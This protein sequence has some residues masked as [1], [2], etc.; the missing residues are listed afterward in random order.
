MRNLLIIAAI[1]GIAFTGCKKDKNV[2]VTNITI[3][4]AT[5]TLTVGEK[6]TL[7]ATVEPADASNKAVTWNSENPE[8]AT[9]NSTTGE[10]TAIAEG[11][12]VITATANDGSNISDHCFV[13]VTGVTL[14]SIAVTTQPTKKIY[15]LSDEFDPAGMVVTATYS[16]NSKESV[17]FGELEFDYN[18][19]TAG[20]D[21][22]VTITYEGKTATVDGITVN[23]ISFSGGD[24]LSVATAYEINMPAQLAW[25]AALVNDGNT[26]YNNKYYKLTADINLSAYGAGFNNGKGWT[27]IGLTYLNPFYGT[28]DGAGYTISELNV[29]RPG[30]E[31]NNGLF[32]IVAAGGT[33]KNLGVK[34]A[35]S[36][37]A[38]N[39]GII[40]DLRGTISNC[41]ADITV[42]GTGN[43]T[44][45]IAG[46]VTGL[47]ENC[48]SE[49]TVGGSI[50]VGGIAGNVGN[51]GVRIKNC[52][53]T[54]TVGGN[55]MVGGIVGEVSLAEIIGCVALNAGISGS[56]NTGRVAGYTH[57]STAT[58]CAG[59]NTLTMTGGHAGEDITATQSQA[60]ATYSGRGW[61]FSAGGWKIDEG[62][63]YP[64]LQWE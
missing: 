34:G 26:D 32:G 49:G 63:S 17:P 55:S 57:F 24:G 1:V 27:P 3:E 38:I 2:S 28:F 21:K 43:Y 8:F 51:T 58:D 23:A 16:D 39:G 12:A 40:A 46:S 7:T 48:Y 61:S 62:V 52:Y 50:R 64:K 54:A 19:S 44:G 42:S 35:V 13:H 45:G 30:E 14:E 59:L 6:K 9:V 60:Q 41:Y 15:L 11:T 37:A 36:G 56:S 18:F 31:D 47:I 5:L 22:T 20:T 10:I 29:N 4:P 53:S 25:L 33:I